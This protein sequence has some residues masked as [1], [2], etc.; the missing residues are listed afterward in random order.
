MRPHFWQ[1]TRGPP[2]HPPHWSGSVPFPP[3]VDADSLDDT[4]EVAFRQPRLGT[5]VKQQRQRS[6]WVPRK[7]QRPTP[8]P[9]SRANGALPPCFSCV[10][11][12]DPLV[13]EPSPSRLV[14]TFTEPAIYHARTRCYRAGSAPATRCFVL[15]LHYPVMCPLR[16]GLRPRGV[17][18]LSASQT[19]PLRASL[20][21][22]TVECPLLVL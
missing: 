6:G 10:T 15:Q 21:P 5:I 19:N 4:P 8:R 20:V 1:V 2:V 22:H 14:Y 3:N 13:V 12:D 9:W 11:F 16:P 17:D 7:L 18:P